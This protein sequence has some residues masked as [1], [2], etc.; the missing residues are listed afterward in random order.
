MCLAA[1]TVER[2]TPYVLELEPILPMKKLKPT[3]AWF[4]AKASATKITG[5]RRESPIQ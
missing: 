5:W 1:K 4:A 3:K 2:F